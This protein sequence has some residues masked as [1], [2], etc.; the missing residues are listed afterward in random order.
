MRF[1]L[2]LTPFKQDLSKPY[3]GESQVHIDFLEVF[4]NSP[5][6]YCLL[7][8]LS[9]T[10]VMI[11]IY[12]F[13]TLK[14]SNML[15]KHELKA[16]EIAAQKNDTSLIKDL[17]SK[18]VSLLSHMMV[19]GATTS[20]LGQQAMLEAMQSAGKRHTVAFWQK[21]ALINDIALI[22]PM[23]GL[24]GTVVGMFYAF[25]DLNRSLDSIHSLFDGLGI[26]VGTTVAG[27]IVAIIAMLFYTLLKYRLMR[28]ITSVEAA[29][30]SCAMRLK[31]E[32][33]S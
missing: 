10:T 15:P 23:I 21:I 13:F 27:L 11:G 14:R 31:N 12:L 2:S 25:Y 29:A 18:K 26:S 20:F 9:F 22:A 33:Y 17:C 24:L 5:V 19:A 3:L 7:F 4:S 32:S 8:F 30:I 6:I 28:I 16:F 1:F